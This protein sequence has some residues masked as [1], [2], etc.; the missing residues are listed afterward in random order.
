MPLEIG[1]HVHHLGS[2][3]GGVE[4]SRTISLH[5]RRGGATD[6][7]GTAETQTSAHRDRRA[8]PQVTVACKPPEGDRGGMMLVGLASARGRSPAT[9]LGMQ[10]QRH[11]ENIKTGA[12]ICR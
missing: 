9:D 8:H 5:Q 4:R 2:A 7:N 11:A 10:R 12:E 1:R 3:T 6:T